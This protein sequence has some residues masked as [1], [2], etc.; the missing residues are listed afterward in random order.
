MQEWKFPDDP[1]QLTPELL[2]AAMAVDR[3]GLV[4]DGEV[5]PKIHGVFRHLTIASS[6]RARWQL[7]QGGDSWGSCQ[8]MGSE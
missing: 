2:T 7:R 6:S 5:F 1:S 4:P 8:V 3:P